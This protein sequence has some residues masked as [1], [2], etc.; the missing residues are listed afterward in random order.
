MSSTGTK[1]EAQASLYLRR[2]PIHKPG[3]SSRVNEEDEFS[4]PRVL[5]AV[6]LTV[7]TI[8]LVIGFF[9]HISFLIDKFYYGRYNSFLEYIAVAFFG[10]VLNL[11][12]SV[13]LVKFLNKILFL[14]E[15][16]EYLKKYS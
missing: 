3:P 8:A 9:Y 10:L 6:F 14:K 12:L 11:S 1:G 7:L 4:V 13:K 15:D 2:K 16:E 5:K